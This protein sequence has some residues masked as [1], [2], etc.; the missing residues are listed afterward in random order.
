MVVGFALAEAMSLGVVLNERHIRKLTACREDLSRLHEEVESGPIG[1]EVIG[2]MLSSILG[3]LGEV[4]GRV[5]S[6]QLLGNIFQR[7]CVGK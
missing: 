1:D 3:G 7:F 6:E 5:F 2:S 4:S